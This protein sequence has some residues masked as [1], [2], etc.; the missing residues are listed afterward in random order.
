MAG[1]SVAYSTLRSTPGTLEV[2]K[3]RNAIADRKFASAP[4][5]LN[6]TGE[7]IGH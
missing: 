1:A 7:L 5:T 2:L 4:T 3:C 6:E